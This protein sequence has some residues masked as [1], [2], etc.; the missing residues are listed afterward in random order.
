[1]VWGCITRHGPGRLHRITG[2]LTGAQYVN[3][4]SESFLGTLRDYNLSTEEAFLQQDNDPKHTC[5]MTRAWLEDNNITTLPWPA[6]SPDQN[7]IEHV[8]NYIDQR[9]HSR[10]VLPPNLDELW[11]ALREEW[12]NMDM[13]FIVGLYE[14]LPRRTAALVEAE[15]GYTKY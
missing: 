10:T 4:L 9:V 3:I 5:K 12:E 15:G 11:D 2:R 6:C 13:E 14:S 8:W 1:M 7:I